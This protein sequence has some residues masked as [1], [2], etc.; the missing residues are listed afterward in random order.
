MA[1]QSIPANPLDEQILALQRQIANGKNDLDVLRDQMAA[2]KAEA[3]QAISAQVEQ[4]H[5][6]R[7]EKAQLIAELT[8]TRV[9][10]LCKILLLLNPSDR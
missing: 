4:I 7:V 10:S 3:Q 2:D 8:Q 6:I 9:I 1:R 5:T